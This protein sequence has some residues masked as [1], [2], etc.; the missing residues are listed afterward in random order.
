MPII[1]NGE[2]IEEDVIG[3][4][5]SEIKGYHERVGRVSC[6]ERDDEFRAQAIEN[7]TGRVLVSQEARKRNEPIPAAEVDEA[8]AKLKEEHGGEQQF[9]FNMGL[10]PEQEGLVRQNVEASLGV[11]K[12]LRE[13][14]G[15][16]P[17]PDGEALRSYYEAHIEDYMTAEEVRA[18]HIFKSVQQAEDREK[19]FGELCDVRQKLVNGADFAEIAAEYS[20]KPA[21][22][23]DLGF[24]KR[25]ELMDEFKV[26]TFSMGVGEIS[27]VF[28]MHGSFH[29]ATVTD[30]K[31]SVPLPLEEVR[32]DV[33]E[34][35]L[36]ADRDVK[37]KA[38]I[39][40][41]KKAAEIEEVEEEDE[42]SAAEEHA[43]R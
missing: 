16:D 17:E 4:E 33:L 28:A 26:V 12:L 41:L 38:Y 37:I 2:R 21:E 23:V 14:C 13:V 34:A 25:G 27:P 19:L 1:I 24:F 15:P 10:S 40:E 11:D 35:C 7:I 22:E 18:S 32:A 39:A 36:Q 30:R 42:F 6:C 3:Q 20:D 9:Y 43:E 5:F 8:V 29:I 31:P